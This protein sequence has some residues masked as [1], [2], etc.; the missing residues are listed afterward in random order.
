VP[1]DIQ[2]QESGD[3]GI[4]VNSNTTQIIFLDITDSVNF[5]HRLLWTFIFVGLAAI[6]V[7]FLTSLY[8]ANRAIKPVTTAWEKQR[9]FVADA[10]HELKTPLAVLTSTYSALQA[11]EDETIKS[12]REYFGYMKS[13][14]DRMAKLI[15]D[16]LSLARMESASRNIVS[17]PYVHGRY[18]TG[19]K[20]YE[21]L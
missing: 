19:Q 12:Q 2:I 6:A 3:N 17:A 5:L 7:I 21:K 8:F 9:Q 1:L 16:L 14:M 11:N 20:P 10:S 18:G 4:A 13:G 15:N